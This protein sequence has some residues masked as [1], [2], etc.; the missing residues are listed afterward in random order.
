MKGVG[1]ALLLVGIVVVGGLL[2]T[3]VSK[4]QRDQCLQQCPDVAGALVVHFTVGPLE[5]AQCDCPK[6]QGVGRGTAR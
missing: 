1:L 4:M 2:A 5:F 3:Y 6:A